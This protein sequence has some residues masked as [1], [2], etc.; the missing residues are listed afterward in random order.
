MVC[1]GRFC[2]QRVFTKLGESEGEGEGV[3][4]MERKDAQIELWKLDVFIPS[5]NGFWRTVVVL[6]YDRVVKFVWPSVCGTFHIA[7][8]A[9]I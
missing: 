7:C 2:V 5:C 3:H 4:S 6:M 1:H 8:A 9:N